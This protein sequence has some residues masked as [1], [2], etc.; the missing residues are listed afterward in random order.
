MVS[1]PT[2]GTFRDE[3]VKV[4]VKCIIARA[5]PSGMKDENSHSAYLTGPPGGSFLSGSESTKRVCVISEAPARQRVPIR[6]L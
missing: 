3:I 2:C 5:A 1:L 6:F 4:G